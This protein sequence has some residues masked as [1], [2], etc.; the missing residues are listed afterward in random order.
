MRRLR[1]WL[2][3]WGGL[4]GKRRQD[5]ELAE[6]LESHLQMHIE[7]NL[8]RG[9]TPEE[10]RRRALVK[11][12]GIE[13]TKENYRDRRG[14][15]WLD[16]LLQDIRFGL[17]ML[18]KNPGFT[19]VAVLT[20][21][22]GIGANTVIFTIVYGVLFRPLPFPKPDRIVQLAETY[23]G[24]SDEMDLTARQLQRLQEYSQAFEHVA[25]YTDV[26]FNLTAGNA[27]EHVRGMPVSADCFQV[28]EVHPAAGRDFLPGEDQGDGER[29]AI[30]SHALSLR[31]FA[32][33]PAPVGKTIS[34]NGDSYTVIGI[35]P[36]GFDPRFA[37]L[38]P[39]VET[40]VWVPLALVAKTAGSGEN[41][42]VIA[43]LKDGVTAPQ[44]NAQMNLVTEQFRKE[45]PHNVPAKMNMSFLPYQFLIGAEVRTYLF[46]L[47][48]AVGFV[49]MIACA[50]VANLLLA[51]GG[52]RVREIAVRIAV[53]ASRV[54]LLRQLLTE[55]MLIAMAGGAL[56]LSVAAAGLKS[57]LATAPAGMPRWGDIHVDGWVFGFTFLISGLTGALFGIAPAIYAS[58]T[59]L[60][61]ALKEGSG[62]ASAGAG[63]SR[64]RQGLVIAEFALSLVL[65]TGAGLMIATFAR[66]M[67]V[68]PGFDSHRV[69][70]MQFWLNGSKYNN[71]RAVADFYRTVEQRI[72]TLPGVEATGVVAGGVPLER[73]GNNGVKI[74]GPKDSGWISMDYREITPG[75]FRTIGVPLKQGRLFSDAD[76]DKSDRVVIVNE[77]A[78][79][80]FFPGHSVLGERLYVSG[81]LCEVVGVVGD[82]KSYLDQPAKPTTFIPAA[83]A[84]FGTSNLFEGWFPRSIVIRTSV[85]P[86]GLARDVREAVVAVDPAVPVGKT[87]SMDQI[88][89]RSLEL[90]SFMMLLLS[91][92]AGLALVLASVGI[93]GV[94]SHAVAQRTRE[95]G[96]RMAL[97]AQPVNL[98]RM[99]L[100][101]G[102]KLVLLG[103]IMG[104]GA[105]LMLTKLL[106]G[107]LYGVSMRDPVIFLLVSFVLLA[108]ALLACWI[109]AGRA[110]RVDPMV[111]LRYE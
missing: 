54:R 41:I 55:S 77:A 92:F 78:A 66:L 16:S 73:G 62:R 12:G 100:A 84:T 13:Q 29:V 107:M 63:R 42:S 53:G 19:A 67:S 5:R 9:M 11:L 109:P 70:T 33:D 44:L 18:R 69:L 75:Y 3:R 36:E 50:N 37:G 4:F 47:L 93:Y 89:S 104:V 21:A 90:Q 71:T 65:L 28:L 103:A 79:R 23:A 95:I 17:R 27:A 83:Q 108:V 2:V 106:E 25:G 76:T 86:L 46:V 30:L 40:D 22:L 111:A 97:G 87:R 72:E 110:M 26:D 94:I 49:L 59:N 43:R 32:G 39:G 31:M 20:L 80:R 56:G 99:L 58:K 15:P 52:S 101:E 24:Q 74:A 102:M 61:E 82:A 35:M 10:A 7:D 105:A 68:S 85:A 6:E 48:G 14:F 98:L 64:L 88:L 60:N 57:L 96:I 38:H 8:G 51:R 34:L 45:F 91:I 1:G 81:V